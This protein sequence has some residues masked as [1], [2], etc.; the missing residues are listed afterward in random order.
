LK[1]PVEQ[2]ARALA[3]T[4]RE[5]RLQFARVDVEDFLCVLILRMPPEQR[6][7]D[8][9]AVLMLG[10]F[11]QRASMKPGSSPDEIFAA[12]AAYLEKQPLNA[13]LL[14]AAASVAREHLA[15]LGSA[16]NALA[17]FSDEKRAGVLGGDGKRPEGTIPA[18]PLARFLV[19]K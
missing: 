2:I 1:D 13:K 18:G 15:T 6:A 11:A 4:D 9:D 3:A 16:G 8:D 17:Q 19:K 5:G 7:L 10:R 14:D 12:V